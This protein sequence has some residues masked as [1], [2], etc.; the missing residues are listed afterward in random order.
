MMSNAVTARCL[1]LV[2]SVQVVGAPALAQP[3][4]PTL[5]PLERVYA[6]PALNGPTLRSPALSPDGAW[7]T[8]LQPNATDAQRL[9]LWGAPVAGGEPRMLVDSRALVPDEGALSPEEIARRERQRIAGSRGIVDYSWDARGE[10]VLVPLGGDLYRVPL[11]D[12][13]RP[14]QLTDT[15]DT[16]ET[17]ARLSPTG[18]AASFIRDGALWSVMI[19]TGVET[20][21]SPAAS[22]TITH[23]MAEFIAQ[24][25]MDRDTGYWWAPEDRFMAYTTVDEAPVAIIP[26]V[27]IGASATAIIDQRYPRAGAANA[28]VS[29]SVHDTTTGTTTQVDLG[30]QADFYLARVDWSKDGHTLYVQRQNRAQTR[31]DL[32][33]VDPR[34]G[35]SRVILSEADPAWVNLTHDFKPLRD[36]TFLWT[37]ERSGWRHISLH[38]ADGSLRRVITAG[39]GWAVRAIEGVDEATGQVFFTTNKADPLAMQLWSAALNPRSRRAAE[40]R[41]ITTGEGTWAVRMNGTGGAF[42]GTYSAPD[43]PPQAGLYRADGTRV[44]WLQENRLDASHPWAAYP[45]ATMRFGTLTGPS[46]DTLHWSMHLPPDF[47]PARRYPVLHYVYGGP[48][49]QVVTRSWGSNVDQFHAARGYIVFRVDNRGTPNRGRDFERAL[50]L[51]LGT[52]EADD[53]LA[54]LNFLRQQPFVNPD[55]IGVWGWS[56]GGYMALRLAVLHPE[57]WNAYA[58]GAPV[59]DWALYDTHYTERYLGKPQTEAHAYEAS[60]VLGRL[61]RVKRPLLIL[62]GM[63]DDNVTFDNATQAFDRLQAASIPFE[64]M[65][66]PGQRHGIREPGRAV[67]VQTTITGFFDRTLAP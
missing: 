17:D 60:A 33:A 10:A 25:E 37:S 5:L 43:T 61:S 46:G 16:F 15:P 18:R 7:A 24:E 59:T 2:F 49:V 55:R 42:I 12:P 47:D 58:A 57:A 62:H 30:S 19:A 48:G 22:G 53:Q 65:V 56:Y 28:V 36:G 23:G 54:G 6:S 38:D 9:D 35:A 31:L 41:Q 21:I 66:Y 11:A 67:H 13:A 64:A 39:E 20:R 50:H 27:E 52:I 40:P 32:L 63:A 51:K 26:R 14:Q 34:T 29:L 45:R 8:W 4:A 1:C 44:R 3:A